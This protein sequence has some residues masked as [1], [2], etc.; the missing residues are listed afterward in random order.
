MR[1]YIFSQRN[2]QELLRDPINLFFGLGFPLVLLL[3]FTLINSNIPPEAQNT[4]FAL[5]RLTPGVAVFGTMFMAL[6]SGMLL[7]RDRTS[8]FLMRLFASPMRSVD[9]IL[10]YTLPM[11]VFAVAQAMITF[12][13]A[14]LL[15]LP[16]TAKILLAIIAVIPVTVLFVGIGLL[17]GSLMNDKAVGGFCGALLTNVAGWLSGIWFSLDLV[18]GGF[19]A[20]ANI[21]PFYHAAEVTQNALSG[22][23]GGIL[24]HLA[25]VLAYSV[26]IFVIAIAVFN[27][28]MSSD[29]T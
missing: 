22:A 3:L 17:C 2:T 15:G 1:I 7:S 23:Y 25:V 21:L 20:V 11:I 5:E 4:M 8:S 19:K 18:G 24:P 29:K 27:R 13:A 9:F 16:L 26:I 14:V 28:K 12:I 6:F 10:G